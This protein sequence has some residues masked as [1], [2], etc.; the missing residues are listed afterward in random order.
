MSMTLIGM[1]KVT[2]A[3]MNLLPGVVPHIPSAYESGDQTDDW[4]D[5]AS[6]NATNT[7]VSLL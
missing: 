1:K 2:V 3:I 7:V 5:I 4:V 6:Y